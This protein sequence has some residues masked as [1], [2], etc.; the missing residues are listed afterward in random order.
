M[1]IP[2]TVTPRCAAYPHNTKVS[3]VYRFII[4]ITKVTVE[5]KRVAAAPAQ[6]LYIYSTLLAL[7]QQ[8][9]ALA[10]ARSETKH[11]P[12]LKRVDFV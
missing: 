3:I 2:I 8:S 9:Y 11:F 12:F 1:V 6:K 5:I 10:K 7:Q 4:T